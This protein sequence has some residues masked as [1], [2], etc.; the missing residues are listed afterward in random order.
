MKNNRVKIRTRIFVAGEGQSEQAFTKWLQQLTDSRD[1]SLHLGYK[2][3]EGGG[4]KSMYHKA[5]KLREKGLRNG[6]YSRGFLL[7]DSDRADR[8]DCSGDW[9]LKELKAEAAKND[10]QICVQYPN[11]EGLLLRIFSNKDKK[12]LNLTPV[13][14]EKHLK[15]IWQ[16]YEK[17]VDALTLSRKL[18]YKGLMSAAD[19]DSDLKNLLRTIG[20]ISI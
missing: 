20:L 15:D 19:W 5:I 3:L 10:L 8:N 16:D 9:S 11:Y 2:S 12:M 17:P 1:L 13:K 6:Q 14:A 18:S 7:V 4:Y